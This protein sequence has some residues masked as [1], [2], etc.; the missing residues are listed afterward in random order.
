MSYTW[1]RKSILQ[2]RSSYNDITSSGTKFW[3][4]ESLLFQQ[5]LIATA[6]SKVVRIGVHRCE[7]FATKPLCVGA[8]DPS[9]GWDLSTGACVGVGGREKSGRYQQDLRGGC[10]KLV[11]RLDGA[12]SAWGP[13]Q[14]CE[15]AAPGSEN[16]QDCRCRLRS[17]SKPPPMLGGR[18]CAGPSI[19]VSESS[20][21]DRSPELWQSSMISKS[22]FWRMT[23]RSWVCSSLVVQ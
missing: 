15:Q 20:W 2:G 9:C 22:T 14:H 12:W 7:R 21:V 16:K 1:Q 6:A 5:F 10:P 23:F 17:C 18:T 4:C 11:R 13:W 8:R 19:Q 3:C